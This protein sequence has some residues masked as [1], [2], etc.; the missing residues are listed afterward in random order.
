M[1]ILQ[2]LIVQ[3]FTF[4]GI[5]L[6]LKWLFYNHISRALNRLKQSNKENLEREKIFKEDFKRADREVKRMIEEAKSQGEEITEQSI[7]EGERKK[8]DIIDQ[9]KKEAKRLINEAIKDCQ[10]K[11]KQIVQKS[12]ETTIS[13]AVDI[14][15]YIFTEQGRDSLHRD[16]FEELINDIENLEKGKIIIV[17]NEAN[18]V[19]AALLEVDQKNK[20]REVLSLKFGKDIEVKED[21]D[22]DMVAG[23]VLKLERFIVDGSI[24]NRIKKILPLMRER[25]KMQ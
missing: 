18:I 24:K 11:D 17:G 13:L 5:V 20:L 16:V 2:L 22:K 12:Q 25:L 1:F 10:N 19:S 23:F 7:R 14:I 3:I 15:K 9:A 21:V 6:F 4:V 8:E